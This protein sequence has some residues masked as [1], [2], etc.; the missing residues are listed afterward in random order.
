[1][2]LTP[3]QTKALTILL[4]QY[5]YYKLLHEEAFKH[6]K[7]SKLDLDCLNQIML[8]PDPIVWIL[9]KNFA[10]QGTEGAIAT[11][12]DLIK[13]CD[14]GICQKRWLFI[15]E[16]I[17]ELLKLAGATKLADVADYLSE[18][19]LN[20]KLLI[21]WKSCEYNGVNGIKKWNNYYAN[22]TKR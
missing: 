16:H 11:L 4:E 15:S 10:Y 18:E 8:F 14:H 22:I 17:P 13:H 6:T 12:S 20:E 1:M 5:Q 3:V 2:T 21:K 9:Y 19:S 7:S